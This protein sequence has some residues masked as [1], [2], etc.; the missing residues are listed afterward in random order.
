MADIVATVDA[1]IKHRHPHVWGERVV[2]GAQEVIHNWEVLKAQER[3]AKTQEGE[4]RPSTL[5]GVPPTLP[6][7]AQAH[8]YGRRAARVGFDWPDV[9]GVVEK[10]DEE[11]AELRAAGDDEERLME[12]GDLLFAVVN[13]ARWLDVDPES[14]LRQANARFAQRFAQIEAQAQRQNLDLL[15]LSLD[16]LEALWQ[17]AKQGRLS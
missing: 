16:E 15:Q 3:Q 11:I 4:E 5:D 12:L 8:A 10:I 2:S 1:K 7:L 6:A 13:W 9:E 14:A 17:A